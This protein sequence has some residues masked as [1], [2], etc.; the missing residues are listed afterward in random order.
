MLIN[1]MKYVRTNKNGQLIDLDVTNDDGVGV[2]LMDF[3]NR[4]IL[5]QYYHVAVFYINRCPTPIKAPGY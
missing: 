3:G 1:F 5:D 2:Q 4:E